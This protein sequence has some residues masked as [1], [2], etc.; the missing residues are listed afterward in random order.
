MKQLSLNF[1]HFSGELFCL[2]VIHNATYI[3]NTFL[4]LLITFEFH[5]LTLSNHAPTIFIY[6]D[7]NALMRNRTTIWLDSRPLMWFSIM[8]GLLF[9]YFTLLKSF[10]QNLPLPGVIFLRFNSLCVVVRILVQTREW[11][12]LEV[13]QLKKN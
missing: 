10:T 13:R 1:D 12:I 8:L 4:I 6:W 7:K 2:L 11:R 5:D 9:Y 3:I